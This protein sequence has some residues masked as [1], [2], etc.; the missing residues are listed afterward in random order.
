MA[1]GMADGATRR[2]VKS[3]SERMCNTQTRKKTVKT[4]AKVAAAI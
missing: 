4:N 1:R 2:S 3:H